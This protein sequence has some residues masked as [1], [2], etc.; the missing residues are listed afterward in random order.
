MINKVVVALEYDG[1]SFNGSQKQDNVRTIQGVFDQVLEAIN[2][3][4]V[5]S[6]FASRTDSGVHATHQVASFVSDKYRSNSSWASA[7]NYYLP[8]DISV[9]KCMTVDNNFD[10]RR[11]AN[12]REY[13][14]SVY[15]NPTISPLMDRYCEHLKYKVNVDDLS[16]TA[17]IFKGSHDFLSFVGRSALE[18]RT[19]LREI[20]EVECSEDDRMIK[21]KF[22]GRSFLHQQIRR[23]VG[24]VLLVMQGKLTRRQ[25]YNALEKPK[26]GSIS[27]LSSSKG[28]CLSN[29]KYKSINI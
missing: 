11:D 4:P 18:D 15:S 20:K 27:S 22:V 23:M 21:I 8:R 5:G 2:K 14:Y 29:I 19:T 24:A 26:K 12:E 6:E 7:L 25:L 9:N 17:Q 13:V 10:V 3:K 16:E 1:T 28:L